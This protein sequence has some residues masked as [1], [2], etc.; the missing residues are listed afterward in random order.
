MLTIPG[1]CFPVQ[2]SHVLEPPDQPYLQLA[3]DQTIDIHVYEPLGDILVFLPGQ[4]DIEQVTYGPQGKACVCL[5]EV[6]V[7][8]LSSSLDCLTRGK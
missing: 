3:V 8:L 5:T 1:R 7:R 2:I 6:L 4:A